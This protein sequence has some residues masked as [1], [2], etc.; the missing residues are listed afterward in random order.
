MWGHFTVV[1]DVRMKDTQNKIIIYYKTLV[2]TFMGYTIKKGN[3]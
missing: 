3:Y 1:Q 2:Y